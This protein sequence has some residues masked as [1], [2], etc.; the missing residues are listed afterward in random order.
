MG[1]AYMINTQDVPGKRSAGSPRLGRPRQHLLLARSEE[2]VAGVILTQI[3]PFAD[4]K[5]LQVFGDFE[6]AVYHNG[7]PSARRPAKAG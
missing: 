7:R 1:L 2:E 4:T 3:L 6:G 5:T